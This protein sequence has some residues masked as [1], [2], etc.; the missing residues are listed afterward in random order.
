MSNGTGPRSSSKKS[1]KKLT[2]AAK[3][4]QKETKSVHLTV[5]LTILKVL[6]NERSLIPL[7]R[8]LTKSKELHTI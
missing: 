3:E 7:L 8:I 1:T 2:T 4:V 6:I 5:E